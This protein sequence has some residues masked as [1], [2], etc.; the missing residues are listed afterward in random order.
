MFPTIQSFSSASLNK[1]LNILLQR[2]KLSKKKELEKQM[3]D[4]QTVSISISKRVICL[5]ICEYPASK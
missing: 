3:A 5:N 4:L 1:K 2:E